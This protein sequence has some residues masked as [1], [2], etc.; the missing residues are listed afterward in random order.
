MLNEALNPAQ[1]FQELSHLD[2]QL[3]DVRKI[4]PHEEIYADYAQDL[5]RK[6][7]KTRLFTTPV[8]VERTHGILLDGHHRFH[9]VRFFLQ[10][11]RIPVLVIDYSDPLLCSVT[12]WRENMVV[13][14]RDVIAAGLNGPLMSQ[15]TSKHS[16]RFTIDDVCIRINDLYDRTPT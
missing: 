9:A 2:V 8:I 4:K 15:K 5:A 13:A 16:F 11:H 3:Y 10:A 14:K 6:I 1:S 7:V 12:S